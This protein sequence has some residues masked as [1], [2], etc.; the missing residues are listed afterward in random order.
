MQHGEVGER[1]KHVAPV[2]YPIAKIP[3]Y[4]AQLSMWWPQQRRSHLILSQGSH[5]AGDQGVHLAA[6][7]SGP[8][9]T[10]CHPPRRQPSVPAR[11]QPNRPN[12][13]CAPAR[14]CAPVPGAATT[15][16]DP[17]RRLVSPPDTPPATEDQTSLPPP[18]LHQRYI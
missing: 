1:N 7:R 11:T 16:P 15:P 2:P 17:L 14:S 5:D 9:A 12:R 18:R 3:I 13:R 8:T 10:W 6:R 4:C